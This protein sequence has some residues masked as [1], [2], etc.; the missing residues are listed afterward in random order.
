MLYQNGTILYFNKTSYL[1]YLQCLLIVLKYDRK[2][3]FVDFLFKKTDQITRYSEKKLQA[4]TTAHD[5][6]LNNLN[7]LPTFSI[8]EKCLQTHL[9]SFLCMP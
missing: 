2:F 9:Q 4:S 5:L 7:I 1:K 6:F 3:N 8:G